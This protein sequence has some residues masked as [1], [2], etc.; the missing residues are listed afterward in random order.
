MDLPPPPPHVQQIISEPSDSFARRPTDAERQLAQAER[1]NE[2]AAEANEIARDQKWSGLL[3]VVGGLASAAF[4]G[5]AALAASRA[6]K[7]SEQSVLFAK[8]QTQPHVTAVSAHV[9]ALTAGQKP[10]CHVLL[11]NTGQAP[12]FEF[13]CLSAVILRPVGSAVS[14]PA[15]PDEIIPTITLGVGGE[16]ELNAD[17]PFALSESEVKD[18]SHN[19]QAVFVIVRTTYRNAFGDW[20]TEEFALESC[21]REGGL[22]LKPAKVATDAVGDVLRQPAQPVRG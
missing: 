11:R 16:S 13:S 5:W 22:K 4:A 8:A 12:A 20:T 21:W 15:V 10:Q 14:L 7:A 19:I 1:A 3:G 17:R 9:V 2:L 18:V 6:A